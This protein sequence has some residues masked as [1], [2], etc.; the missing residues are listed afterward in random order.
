MVIC[1]GRKQ[2]G[3]VWQHTQTKR[4]HGMIGKNEATGSTQEEAFR[5]VAAKAFGFELFANSAAPRGP[6]PT[7]PSAK[8]CAATSSRSSGSSAESIAA[9]RSSPRHDALP[10]RKTRNDYGLCL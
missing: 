7:T 8:C 3:K 5:N 4:F 10:H 6:Q 9:R 1:Q 2:V